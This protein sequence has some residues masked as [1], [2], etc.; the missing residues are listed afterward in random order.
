MQVWEDAHKPMQFYYAGIQ[1][2]IHN[3]WLRN[4]NQAA[5]SPYDWLPD[6][7]RPQEKPKTVAES[8]LHNRLALFEAA[9]SLAAAKQDAETSARVDVLAQRWEIN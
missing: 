8:M 4:E 3:A 9:C 2:S 6:E 5:Y 7:D 1:A